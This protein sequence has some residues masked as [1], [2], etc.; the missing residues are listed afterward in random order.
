MMGRGKRR[1][2]NKRSL[3]GESSQILE[4]VRSDTATF[5]SVLYPEVVSAPRIYSFG[6]PRFS[7]GDTSKNWGVDSIKTG[8]HNA[9]H[10]GRNPK[11][12]WTS[13]PLFSRKPVA[14]AWNPIQGA[15]IHFILQKSREY[16]S[17]LRKFLSLFL[18]RVG[19]AVSCR[20]PSRVIVPLSLLRSLVQERWEGNPRC[21]SAKTEQ[22]KEQPSP[23]CSGPGTS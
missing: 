15:F 6:C 4:T 10:T 16:P 23:R 1:R 12:L 20:S 8:P 7:N 14:M 13:F 17:L 3:E 19:C 18:P 2:K 11:C 9:G 5:T 21:R 22:T